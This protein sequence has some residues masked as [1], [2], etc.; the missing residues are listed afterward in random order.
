MTT[1]SYIYMYIYKTVMAVVTYQLEPGISEE[2]EA[3]R[4][5]TKRRF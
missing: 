3:D 4:H 2:L 1:Y 5:R